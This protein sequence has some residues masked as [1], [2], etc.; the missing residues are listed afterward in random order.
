MLI[1]T[2]RADDLGLD[3]G[4]RRW[5]SELGRQARPMHLR[6]EGL[7]REEMAELIAGILGHDPEWTLVDAVWARSQGNPS[8]PRS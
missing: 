6:L 5:L 4:L 1:G 8:S 3:P 2:Y 7:G